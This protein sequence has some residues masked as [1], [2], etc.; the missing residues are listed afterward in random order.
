MDLEAW[1]KSSL[2]SNADTTA[3]PVAMASEIADVA[4]RYVKLLDA[5]DADA[6]HAELMVLRQLCEERTAALG[7]LPKR[8]APRRD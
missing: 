8:A 7:A 2:P 6:A 5:G 1:I 4:A 3:V